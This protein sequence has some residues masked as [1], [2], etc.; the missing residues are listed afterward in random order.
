[1]NVEPQPVKYAGG[2]DK[3]MVREQNEDSVLCCGFD[4]SDVSLLLVADGVGGHE[5]GAVA[6]KLAVET[7][8]SVISKAVLL[9]HSGG[10]YAENWLEISLYHAIEEANKTLLEQQQVQPQL[11]HMA[12]TIVALLVQGGDAALSHLGDSRC[13]VYQH[14]VLTQMT[15]DH[16]VLQKL[17]NEGKINQ[18]Q[19]NELPMH[20]MISN[21]LGLTQ[22]PEIYT[23]R[24]E[25][26]K[27]AFYLLC[28]DGLTN[29]LSDEDIS[30]ILQNTP[31][32]ND[33][34]DTLITQANDNGGF[35]NISVVLLDT[36][37]TPASQ[38]A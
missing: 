8:R 21:A 5:G 32:L 14:S 17:L 31:D 20:H 24:F 29:C 15:E 16:T 25:L 36:C 7:I 10:G 37:N 22:N 2:T 18:T 4:H 34:V 13:Y 19:F 38:D 9:A 12:T 23:Q 30:T 35:D 3:G 28:S 1:M 26:D 27:N 33:C 11:A 6:S